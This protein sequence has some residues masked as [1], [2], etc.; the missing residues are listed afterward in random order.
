MRFIVTFAAG[1]SADILARRL[2]VPL[3]EGL[4]VPVVVENRP[5]AGGNIGLEAVARAAPDGQVFGMGAPGPLA[6][7]P[8]LPNARM[9]FDP[10]RDFTPV[11]HLADQPNVLLTSPG[12]PADGL[13]EFRAWALAHAEE[14][15]ASPGSGTS[16]HLT[17]LAIARALGVRWQH[18]PYRGSAPAHAD[19]LA[20]NLRLMVDNIA[21]ALPFLRDGR[22]KAALVSTAERA[23][24]LPLVPSLAELG[25]P[26]LASWQ[27]ILAPA[28][29]PAPVLER[30]NAAFAAALASPSV[31]EWL[32]EAGATPVA[33]PPERFAAFLAA[34]RPRW[35]AL[36]RENNVSVD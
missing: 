12:L 16:N 17:G 29:L 30:L 8:A 22:M 27:G 6:I 21:T 15:F 28:G 35:A 33:G 10:A 13:S 23:P 24:L 11:I 14:P 32:R 5:G 20:G 7:N 19:L 34:E 2:A 18:V 4:G 36:V 25:I 26:G 3:S 1:G 31:A 9:P